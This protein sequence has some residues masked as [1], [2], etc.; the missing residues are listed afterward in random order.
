MEVHVVSKV[1]NEQHATFTFPTASSPAVELPPSSIRI[2][3]LLVSLTSNNLS[4]ARGGHSLHWCAIQCFLAPLSAFLALNSSSTL[5][6]LF[7]AS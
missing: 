3:V 1:D 2:R 7:L 5:V 4:Y 6:R